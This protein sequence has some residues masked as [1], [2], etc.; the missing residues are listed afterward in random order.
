MIIVWSRTAVAD[1]E[2]VR[3]YIA[4]DDPKAAQDIARRILEAVEQLAAFPMSGRAGRVPDTRELVVTGTPFVI[5][6]TVRGKR[7]EIIAVLH[8]ARQWPMT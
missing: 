6:Y 8:S 3:R 1:L 4:D 5:P 2:E 7:I